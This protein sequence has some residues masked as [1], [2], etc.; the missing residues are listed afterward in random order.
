MKVVDSHTHL[1]DCSV[2]DLE[3]TE[4]HLLEELDSNEVDAA[5]VLPFPGTSDYVDNHKRISNLSK[6]NPGR[7]YGVASI[8]PR[9]SEEKYMNE[10]DTCVN[11][12]GFVGLKMHTVGHAIMPTSKKGMFIAEAALKYQIPL[13][14]H[15][16]IGVPFALPSMCIPLAKEFPELKIIL[17]HCGAKIYVGEAI[18]A[19][20]ECENIYLETSWSSPIDIK[21]MVNQFGAKRVM[22]GSDGPDNI[23]AEIAKHKG[24]KIKEEELIE[25]LGGAALSVFNI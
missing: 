23:F 15:T 24:A 18:L 17:A 4:E 20:K 14:V 22:F 16:G 6:K 13:I 10:L 21:K 8:P 12:Y 3:V 1:G 2:F 9:I 25:T 5:I 19:A 7:I 11:E